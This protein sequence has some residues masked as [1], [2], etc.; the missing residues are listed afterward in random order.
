M[1]KIFI[2]ALCLLAALD[3]YSQDTSRSQCDVGADRVTMTNSL[4][5]IRTPKL[6]LTPRIN[7]PKIFGVR[8]GSPFLFRIPATGER[9]MAFAAENLPTGLSLDANTGII[10]GSLNER[11][12]FDVTLVAS[13][14]LGVAKRE[15]RIEVGDRIALTPPMGWNTYYGFRLAISDQ[16]IREQ[17][18]AMVKS[19]LADH[20]WSY[21][22]LD[23]GWTVN[24]AAKDPMLNGAP[25]ESDG[26]IRANGRFP[27]MKALCDYVHEKG[28]RIGLYSSPGPLN[29]GGF[30]GSYQ[31]EEQDAQSYADWGFDFLKYDWCSYKQI[32]KDD[33]VAEARKPYELMA[34]ALRKTQRD[35]VFSFCQYGM[36]NSAEWAADAGANTWRTTRDII[37]KWETVSR[38]G[39]GQAGLEKFSGPGRWNDPDMLMVGVMARNTPSRL[40]P[41]EQYAHV[42]LW[43]LLNAPLIIGGDLR[44]L[45][46]F[47]FGLLTNDEVIEVNQ[48]PL[49]QQASR[50]AQD[51]KAQ[52]EVWA[53]RMED[54]SRAVGLFNRSGQPASVTVTWSAL[55]LSDP[56]TVRDLWRQKNLG[57]LTNEFSAIIP[58]HGVELIRVQTK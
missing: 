40:M 23:E 41:D 36:G 16:L 2:G 19:G 52:T 10:T 26:R 14:A 43:C 56:Q 29:C 58:A 38:Y 49:G 39:F 53:K 22:N 18:D 8:P 55:Q 54:G 21:I 6:S 9:P 31:H 34:C 35:I 48:D 15:F 24:L 30:V 25:R 37:D 7:G 32:A 28:L 42:S 20:G 27:D 45:D 13:N 11:G 57:V 33:S 5:V 47:T 3:G 44:K 1:E 50:V 4:I 12:T 46:D 17:A 51:A